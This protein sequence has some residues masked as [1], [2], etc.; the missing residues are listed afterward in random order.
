M[1]QQSVLYFYFEVSSLKGRYKLTVEL[2]IQK[3]GWLNS[4]MSSF[5]QKGIWARF[6]IFIQGVNYENHFTYKQ[7]YICVNNSDIA[8]SSIYVI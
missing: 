7:K 4:S 1:F 2:N 8:C 6:V 5:A 3:D